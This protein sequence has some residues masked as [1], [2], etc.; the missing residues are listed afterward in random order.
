MCMYAEPT[1]SSFFPPPGRPASL[2]ARR[3][4][5]IAG[6]IEKRVMQLHAASASA[7]FVQ[8]GGQPAIG[9]PTIARVPHTLDQ[10]QGGET[11]GPLRPPGRG[12]RS[13]VGFGGSL[14]GGGTG[15]FF[16]SGKRNG[17][18]AGVRFQK[19][20][21]RAVTSKSKVKDGVEKE[22]LGLERTIHR[23]LALLFASLSFFFGLR[24]FF[25]G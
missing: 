17:A 9:R 12:G 22:T 5:S 3:A 16:F 25:F 8:S 11:T 14:L 10:S 2:L 4:R 20:C 7:S 18:A 13:S 24:F 15:R 6:K 1:R 21:S 23:G 19:V